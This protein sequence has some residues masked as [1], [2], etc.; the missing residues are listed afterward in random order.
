MDLI[1]TLLGFALVMGVVVGVHEAGHYFAGRLFGTAVESFSFGFGKSLWERTDRRGTRWRL[2]ALPLGGFVKFVNEPEP[3]GDLSP[4]DAPVPVGKPYSALTPGQRIVVSLAGPFA[5][6]VLASL[7]FA[8]IL[9]IVGRPVHEVRVGEVLPGSPAQAAGFLPGDQIVSANG[10]V[11]DSFND[12]VRSVAFSSGTPV[13]FEI[14]REG[15]LMSLTA[16]P[17]RASRENELGQTIQVGTVGIR[18]ATGMPLKF[19]TVSPLM[20]VPAGIRETVDT[21][22]LS[23]TMMG[24]LITGREPISNL[25][26]PVGIADTTGR[27]IGIN[28]KA[29]GAALSDRLWGVFWTIVQLTALISVGIGV[30]N[31]LPFPILDGGHVVFNGWE[32]LTKRAV[33]EKVQNASLTFGF[34]LLIGVA[35]IV[36]W[37]DVVGTGVLRSLGVQ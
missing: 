24:R 29:E 19:V 35:A 22:A 36:T 21:T 31:L 37:H 11:L 34:I 5:N 30:V 32:M 2:N 25:K 1:T 33:P 18:P 28:V 3:L 6:F 16:V 15:Q 20:A 14:R 4:D 9:A 8:L 26:G 27:A 10:R 7:L 23:F 17:E 13:T 12:L